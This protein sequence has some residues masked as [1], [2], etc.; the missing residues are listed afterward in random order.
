MNKHFCRLN[1]LFHTDP[2]TVCP[3]QVNVN[4]FVTF[5]RA[6]SDY[7]SES[8]LPMGSPAIAVFLA[9]VDTTAAGRVLY[10][11]VDR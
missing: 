2:T 6:M 7:S 11:W 1:Y 8:S 3:P 5:D 9:D 10:R 4:G